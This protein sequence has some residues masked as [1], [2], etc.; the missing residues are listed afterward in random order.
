MRF[1]RSADLADPHAGQNRN[2]HNGRTGFGQHSEQH[3]NLVRRVETP[4]FL[5][6][7]LAN[8]DPMSRISFEVT[9][10]D[11]GTKHRCKRSSHTAESRAGMPLL[12]QVRQTR[13]NLRDTDVAQWQLAQ[14]RQDVF[15]ELIGVNAHRR[16][17]QRQF[18][19]RFPF[20]T[21]LALHPASDKNPAGKVE[22][23]FTVPDVE[24]FYRDMSAKGVLFTMPPKKQDFGGVLAQFVDS[25]RAHFSV[26][27]EAA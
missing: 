16:F 5:R 8:D 25:E 23:G 6:I 19:V 26:G 24:A 9:A 14:R 27:A 15:F 20:E 4:L 13:L 10:L 12:L 18:R 17:L 22:L 21:T 3:A 7:A 2:R 11:G 1:Q